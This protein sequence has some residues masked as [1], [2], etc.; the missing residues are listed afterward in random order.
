MLDNGDYVVTWMGNGTGDGNGVFTQR[1]SATGAKIGTE[2][3]V[4]TLTPNDQEAP[5]ITALSDGGYVIAWK[6][7]RQDGGENWGVFAQRFDASGAKVG[8]EFLVNFTTAN[9]QDGVSVTELNDGSLVFTWES[10][11]QDGSDD[12]VYARRFS[13][14]TILT[15]GSEDTAYVVSAADLLAQFRDAD[16]DTLTI[17][18]LTA[19]SGTVVDN[20]D[21][22]Y[23]ITQAVNFNGSVTLS[24]GVNDGT[25]T[26]IMGLGYTV[27]AA[28]DAPALTGSQST[29]SAGTEDTAYVVT[30]AQLLAGFTDIDG[31]TLSVT[32]LTASNGTVVNNGNGTYTITPSTNFNGSV[33]LNY[34]V[35]DGTTTTAATLGY[36][37]TAVNDAPALTGTQS[38]LTA[39]TEDTAYTVTA[40][41]L[42]AGFADVD[43]D[44]LSVTGLTASNGTVVNNGDGTFT[45]T[46]AANF[47]GAMT[48]NYGVS[49]GTATMA[50]TLG[51]TVT[52]VNDAPALTETQTSLA[53]GTEDVA[54]TVTSAQLLAGYTDAE[55]QAL[56]VTGLSASH[57][58]VVNNGNGTY[59]ITPRANYN[60]TMTL[61][62][63]VSDGTAT[64][65]ATLTYGLA[66]VIDGVAGYTP[67]SVSLVNADSDGDQ[68]S[69]SVTA[70]SDGGYVIVFTDWSK[71]GSS[72]GIFARRFNASGQAV[73]SEFRVNT[74][75]LY[76]Q[77][78]PFVSATA[79]GGFVV[80]WY[81]NHN[82]G[83]Y[84]S[85]GDADLY[86]QRYDSSG[87]AV[88]G[89]TKLSYT[90]NSQDYNPQIAG[91]ANGGYVITWYAQDSGNTPDVAAQAYDANGNTVGSTFVVNTYT[92]NNQTGSTITALADG[93]YIITWDGYGA[94]NTGVPLTYGQRFDSSHLRVGS[95]F[96]ISN[97]QSSGT[98]VTELR[99]GGFVVSF[100]AYVPSVGQW[101]LYFQRFDAAGVA[102]GTET[103]VS[104]LN[105]SGHQSPNIVS[106]NGGG[107]I[108]VWS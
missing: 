102:V 38:T 30:A 81:S 10:S 47:N 52:A 108:V 34:N 70:L 90:S 23:T 73:G 89:E 78:Y 97:Y 14:L 16:S 71:D 80:A 99:D 67:G 3:R 49:D 94:A 98:S 63:G 28:N 76:R 51:Y 39:G 20:G 8:S 54:Y 7:F 37:V 33:T 77:D 19:S 18:S 32:G 59:T 69:Q 106:L 79:D 72:A 48:L 42:L 91:L 41:Q 105:E 56:S 29:L 93:G 60:G 13:N 5:Y 26:T 74:T 103:R 27:A 1:L 87:N 15:S 46:P 62:Y 57:G 6:S 53:A 92:S 43:N 2:V 58:T 75:T 101:G 17:A 85:G 11:G 65:N 4:N 86:V 95:N 96:V 22:T 88:G 44:T 9:N 36:N 35:S 84:Y 107:F 12:G 55:G 21:G 68:N 61:S 82:G 45:I 25:T 40:A 100:T 66:A 24:L 31:N 64:T 104:P 50:A 83:N